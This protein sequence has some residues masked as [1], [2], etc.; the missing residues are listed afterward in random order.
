MDAIFNKFIQA[1]S[2][3]GLSKKTL[4]NYKSDAK[5]FLTWASLNL[6]SYGSYA[7]N[8]QDLLP[9]LSPS[10]AE[11]YKISM[12]SKYNPRS[13]I[14]R[15]LTTLRKLDKFLVDDGLYAKPFTNE[16]VNPSSRKTNSTSQDVIEKFRLHLQKQ[17]V[18]KATEKNYI[19]DIKH[20]L[21]WIENNSS[22][23][24]PKGIN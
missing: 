5:H 10:L 18:S 9:H 6:L 20:F 22:K 19:S 24:T 23:N 13:T 8:I 14:S 12:Q 11:E 16:L 21:R 17:K 15:R 2:K 7:K 4:K 1:I 3:Q